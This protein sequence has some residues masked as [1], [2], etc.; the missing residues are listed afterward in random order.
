MVKRIIS[1]NG[2]T[3][4]NVQENGTFELH[5]TPANK[6][7]KAFAVAIPTWHGDQAHRNTAS[8]GEHDRANHSGANGDIHP[9]NHTIMSVF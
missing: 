7:E 9:S 4:D 3:K 8:N 1:E 5:Y 2:G 6:N